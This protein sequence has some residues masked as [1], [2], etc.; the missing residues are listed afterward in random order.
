M[1]ALAQPIPLAAPTSEPSSAGVPAHVAIIMDG[2]RRWA[3]ARGLPAAMGH[4]AGAEA[5]R[6]AVEACG[7]LGIRH[8]TLFAFSSE[9]WARAEEEVTALSGLLRHYLRHE[10]SRLHAQGVR[11]SV[12]GEPSRFGAETAAAVA[13]AEARTAGNTALHLT[14]ALSYGA[15]AEIAAAARKL[16]IE[17]A[18][19]RMRPDEIDEDA[20]ASRLHTAGTPDPDL[21][22]RTSGERRIS[23]FLLW[24]VAYA[25]FVFLDEPWPDFG[26]ESLRVAVAEFARRQRRFGKG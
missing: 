18:A 22:I 21:L 4:R 15:R 12:I 2:N 3:K 19:G 6:R 16:A 20:I 10:L 25:E 26:E 17:V 13:D 9:N 14:I 8:L 11:L 24:Q 23:N 5:V 7:A 1:N